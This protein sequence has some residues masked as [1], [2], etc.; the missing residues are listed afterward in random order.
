MT[1]VVHGEQGQ[2][3]IYTGILSVQAAFDGSKSERPQPFLEV[4]E[5]L[6]PVFLKGDNPFSNTGI[7]PF[8]NKQVTCKGV[9]HRLTFVVSE[10]V[11]VMFQES[12]SKVEVAETD[13]D[14]QMDS[15]VA[16]KVNSSSE[17]TEAP[18]VNEDSSSEE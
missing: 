4:A 3:A 6:V 16:Q 5:G 2:S 15:D 13:D 18:L 7:Q 11:E 14:V 10:I 1:I 17:P 9:W 12:F 8:I